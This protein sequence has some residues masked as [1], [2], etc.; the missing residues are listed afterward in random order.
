VTGHT[1]SMGIDKGAYMVGCSTSKDLEYT[2]GISSWTNTH[3]IIYP[4]GKRQLINIISGKW[5]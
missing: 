4:N 2:K 3:C 5:R 1:H